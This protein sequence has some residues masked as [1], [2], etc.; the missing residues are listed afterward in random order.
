MSA[1]LGR[2]LI[3]NVETASWEDVFFVTCA[4]GQ[5]RPR[6][7][8]VK[9][10]DSSW[11]GRLEGR[12]KNIKEGRGKGALEEVQNSYEKRR[13]EKQA[14]GPLSTGKAKEQSHCYGL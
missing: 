6:R 11:Q 9:K 7:A 3:L 4:Q 2:E 8:S 14:Q 12:R 10:R 13:K 5:R 1:D